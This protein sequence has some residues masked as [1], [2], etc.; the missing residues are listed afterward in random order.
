MGQF[1]VENPDIGRK[2]S[3]GNSGC[4]FGIDVLAC[5]CLV[6]Y[7]RLC[8]PGRVCWVG[9]AVNGGFVREFRVFTTI[10]TRKGRVIQQAGTECAKLG[11]ASPVL[12]KLFQF[13]SSLCQTPGA[14]AAQLSSQNLVD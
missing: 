3:F 7:T 5:V 2:K 6:V 8:F 12:V 1:L 10:S 11:P 9:Q 14:R 13:G 4:I